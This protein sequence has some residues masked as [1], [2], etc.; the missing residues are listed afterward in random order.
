MGVYSRFRQKV[1]YKSRASFN[2]LVYGQISPKPEGL[3]FIDPLSINK[4]ILAIKRRESGKVVSR[5]F[6]ELGL[7]RNIKENQKL[8][9][10]YDRWVKGQSWEET[11][12]YELMLRLIS[13]SGKPVDGC[14]NLEDIKKRYAKLDTMFEEVREQQRIKP[15]YEIWGGNDCLEPDGIY[16]HLNESSELVFGG[17]GQ[18]RL[19]IAR[20]LKLGFVPAQIGIVHVNALHYYAQIKERMTS[21]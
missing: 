12:V 2:N 9:A 16:V 14:Y 10:C 8:S 21:V 6:K 15:F 19:A 7:V 5:N 11:G 17:G 3:V 4:E 13:N 1:L 18:H 20:I